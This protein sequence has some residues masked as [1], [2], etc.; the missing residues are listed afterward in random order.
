MN[1]KLFAIGMICFI[2]FCVI[3]DFAHAQEPRPIVRLIYFLPEDREPDPDID[4]KMEVM[5][6]YIQQF[7]ADEMERNGFGRKTFKYEA[8]QDGKA[9]I[10][11]LTENQ[12]RTQFDYRRDIYLI[13]VPGQE[14]GGWGGANSSVSGNANI[15]YRELYYPYRTAIHE[16]GHAFGLEHDFRSDIYLMSYGGDYTARL[17]ECAARWLDIHRAFND[18]KPLLNEDKP[19]RIEMLPTTLCLHPI[20]LNS[21]L[22]CL[23]RMDF[24]K[25]NFLYDHLPRHTLVLSVIV[26]LTRILSA[27]SP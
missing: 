23:I 17:S 5:I 18:D 26:A 11:K 24:T 25:S 12:Y 22:R 8:D 16:L 1:R 4:E 3:S 10:H 7:F 15:G 6:K 14:Y 13:V 9:V 20:K 19:A 21:G 27:A 2:A